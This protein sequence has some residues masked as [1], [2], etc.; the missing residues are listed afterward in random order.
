MIEPNSQRDVLLSLKEIRRQLEE[1]RAQFGD[2][3]LNEALNRSGLMCDVAD[4]AEDIR[5]GRVSGE[6]AQAS[7]E[8][9]Q[10]RL[11][12]LVVEADNPGVAMGLRAE[13]EAADKGLSSTA[14]KLATDA[15]RAAA[16]GLSAEEWT[17]KV[18]KYYEQPDYFGRDPSDHQ[19]IHFQIE[20][21]RKAKV[22]P[23]LGLSV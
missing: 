21:L 9:N 23:W 7:A 14:Q 1:M 8:Q 22:W 10:R 20:E 12:A 4:L 13:Y 2:E 11:E 18:L 19:E 5:K 16:E 6:E 15:M 3:V 17:S